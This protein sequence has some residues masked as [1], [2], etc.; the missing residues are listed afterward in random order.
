MAVCE[1]HMYDHLWNVLQ[2]CFLRR[3]AEEF[4]EDTCYAVLPERLPVASARPGN[5]NIE[6]MSMSFLKLYKTDCLKAIDTIDLEKV[7]QAIAVL[8][9]ARDE[10]RQI[11]I[12]GNGGSASA[13]SHFA[14]DIVK[15]ASF[16]RSKRFRIMAL[17]DSLP[18]LTAYSNDVS[19]ECVFA[20]QLKNFARP[21][22]VVIA[23]SGS[24]NSPNV[25]R[26]IEYGNSIGCRTIALSGRDGGKLGPMAQLNIQVSHPHT[27]RIE[28]GH[29]IILHM[30]G[31]YFMDMEK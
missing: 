26:A 23:I 25:L 5:R 12:C 7:N 17:T 30:I 11:F 8:A 24:G 28:D 4:W 27:G 21:G 16:Q 15:G 1:Y 29:L 20:E 3:H 31:Y 19:Y 2:P 6:A 10:D 18:T 13:A 22:D 14:C 9:Q